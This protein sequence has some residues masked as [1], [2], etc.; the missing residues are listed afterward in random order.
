MNFLLLPFFG[1]DGDQ[2]ES[3]LLRE[4]LKLGVHL[5]NVAQE[6]FQ[7]CLLEGLRRIL[8]H[9][10]DGLESQLVDMV[11]RVLV[12]V[13][14]LQHLVGQVYELLGVELLADLFVLGHVVEQREDLLPAGVCGRLILLLEL[15]LHEQVKNLGLIFH[16]NLVLGVL[17]D[18]VQERD[19]AFI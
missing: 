18:R 12:D 7:I 10:D 17:R 1:E 9:V 5:A 19:D 15:P 11:S 8:A 3:I 16:V 14:L 4:I 13:C 6:L 2:S